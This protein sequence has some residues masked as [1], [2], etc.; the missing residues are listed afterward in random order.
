MA[1]SNEGVSV[2]TSQ[3]V[4]VV[5]NTAGDRTGLRRRHHRY[6]C[7]FFIAGEKHKDGS[8][9]SHFVAVLQNPMSYRQAVHEGTVARLQ[10]GDRPAV[11]GGAERTMPPGY[12]RVIQA[13]RV[14][15]IPAD[16]QFLAAEMPQRTL[17]RTVDG[18][19]AGIH[20]CI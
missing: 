18:D 14:G 19:Q 8:S 1:E 9:D 17:Q 4:Y 13:Q 6:G 7:R 10:I 11:A 20:T 16:G 12:G 3:P 5:C 15:G 2:E